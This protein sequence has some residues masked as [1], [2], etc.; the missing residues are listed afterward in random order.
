LKDR[1]GGTGKQLIVKVVSL[2][3][4]AASSVSPSSSRS[5]FQTQSLS[6]SEPKPLKTLFGCRTPSNCAAF[7]QFQDA[8]TRTPPS[9]DGSSRSQNLSRNAY[10]QTS[11]K[12]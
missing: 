12:V 2:A 11:N 4:Q 5:N 7:M 9:R 8:G 1:W 3:V 10:I 6:K